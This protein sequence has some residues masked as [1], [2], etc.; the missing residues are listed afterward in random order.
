ME[1]LG[2]DL[3]SGDDAGRRALGVRLHSLNA[4]IERALRGGKKRAISGALGVCKGAH[5]RRRSLVS[6]HR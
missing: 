6:R 4:A 5:C 2:T 3:L 1:S